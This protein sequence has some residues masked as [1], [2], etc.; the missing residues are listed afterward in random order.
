MREQSCSILCLDMVLYLSACR[1]LERPISQRL[2]N[3]P[4]GAA[5]LSTTAALLTFWQTPVRGCALQPLLDVLMFSRSLARIMGW[6][7]QFMLYGYYLASALGLRALSPPLAL[8]TAQETSLSGAF[9]S[10]HQVYFLSL[11]AAPLAYPLWLWKCLICCRAPLASLS[12]PSFRIMPSRGCKRVSPS[13]CKDPC[14]ACQPAM[15]LKAGE[16][17]AVVQ[18]LVSNAEEVAFNDPPGGAAERLILNQH[19][20]R[21]IR[22]SRL[23]ALQRFFQQVPACIRLLPACSCLQQDA[24]PPPWLYLAGPARPFGSEPGA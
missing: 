12:A 23:S 7:G 4:L 11:A 15:R 19:L 6:R 3:V 17:R 8:I 22:H 21:L 10:A 5:D 1:K 14:R 2:V 13:S 9:R 24:M 20:S 18:R 16:P